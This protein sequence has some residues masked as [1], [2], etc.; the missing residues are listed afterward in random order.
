MRSG[1]G[2]GSATAPAGPDG[3][4]APAASASGCPRLIGGAVRL[5]DPILDDRSD[6]RTAV[7]RGTGAKGA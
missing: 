6:D 3:P 4:D 1:P 5:K 2:S 7:D